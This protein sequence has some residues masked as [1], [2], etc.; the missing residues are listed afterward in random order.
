MV[1]LRKPM[2]LA[3]WKMAMT[4]TESI[5]FAEA[6]RTAVGDLVHAV[7]IVL[8]PPYTAL[9]PL[10]QVLGKTPIAIGAQDFCAESGK[11]HTGQ[12]SAPLL[13]EA[14]CKWVM[15][16][17]WEVRRR[18]GEDDRTLNRKVHAALQAGLSPILL[19]GEAVSEKCGLEEALAA[20]MPGLLA[21]CEVQDMVEAA[22]IYEPEW[23][24]GGMEPPPPDYITEGCGLIR[25]WTAR[26]CGKEAAEGVRIIY[27]GSVAPENAERLLASSEVD[28][29]GAGRKGRDPAAFAQ[30]V[31][32]IARVKRGVG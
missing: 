13:A 6:F 26:A 14:G 3:N 22:M 12:I 15:V 1:N 17:H 29:L 11:S 10:C 21:Q 24:I 16:G 19:L 4:V 9:Y 25:H 2:A 28:G 32:L 8:C 20:R 7:D 27:G 18:T 31:K 5:S 30:I 23:T